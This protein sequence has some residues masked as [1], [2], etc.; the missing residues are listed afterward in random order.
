MM[1]YKPII[2]LSC[3]KISFQIKFNSVKINE[4]VRQ[5]RQ[6]VHQ[7]VVQIAPNPTLV[8]QGEVND[9]WLTMNIINTI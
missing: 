8:H 4:P 1:R 7:L 2:Q 9:P 6:R 3:Q 5:Y